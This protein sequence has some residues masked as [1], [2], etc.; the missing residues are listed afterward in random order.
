[1]DI[2]KQLSL[3]LMA[4]PFLTMAASAATIVDASGQTVPHIS[5]GTINVINENFKDL[6]V[7]IAG[8]GKTPDGKL[9]ITYIQKIPAGEEAKFNIQYLGGTQFYS[10]TGVVVNGTTVPFKETTC[11]N[12]NVDQHYKVTFTKVDDVVTHCKAELLDESGQVV[13]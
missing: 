13:K 7:A 9:P 1:M 6:V 2:K 5:K 4:T 11:T 12:L 3:F 8:Q 10:I